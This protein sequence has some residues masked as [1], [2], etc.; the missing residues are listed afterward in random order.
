[1]ANVPN[2][3]EILPKILI[4]WVGCTNVQ[5]DDRRQTDRQTG[6]DLANVNVNVSLHSLIKTD[7]EPPM[8][9]SRHFDHILKKTLFVTFT[10]KPVP[11]KTTQF[12]GEYRKYYFHQSFRSY[13]V[14]KDCYGHRWL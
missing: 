7:G 3:V 13:R 9:I 5:T 2:S 12:V 4:V 1:M 10:S 11:L 8:G 14:Q 6:D